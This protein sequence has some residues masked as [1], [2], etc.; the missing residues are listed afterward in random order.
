M[1]FMFEKL[2]VYQ[3]AVNLAEKTINATEAIARGH[4]YLTDQLN[5]AVLSISANLAE[6]NGRWHEKD[7]NSSFAPPADLLKSAFRYWNCVNE[8]N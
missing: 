2:N 1:S 6:G 4:Y 5:R 3:K 8:N 7:R